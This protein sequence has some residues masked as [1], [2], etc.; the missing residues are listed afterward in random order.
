MISFRGWQSVD[1]NFRNWSQKLRIQEVQC[2]LY[3]GLLPFGQCRFHVFGTLYMY[4][5]W[6]LRWHYLLF[7]LSSFFFFFLFTFFFK[8]AA[9]KR[10]FSVIVAEGAPFYKVWNHT[11]KVYYLSIKMLKHNCMHGVDPPRLTYSK[12]IL[13]LTFEFKV[14]P[15]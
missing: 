12:I 4:L 9:R 13:L 3:V 6:F 1:I 7:F 8:N 10:K 15:F 14:L 5:L 2:T 11:L